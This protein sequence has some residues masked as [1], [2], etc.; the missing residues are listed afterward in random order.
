M[1]PGTKSAASENRD[2]G[3]HPITTQMQRSVPGA[4]TRADLSTPPA[5]RG[6][7]VLIATAIGLLITAAW[8][9]PFVDKTLGENI[10]DTVLGYDA[11]DASIAG[12]L[13]GL[14][15]AFAA[16]LAGTFTACN[17]AAFS[18]IA[19]MMAG[20]SSAT[21]RL[22]VA[23][24]P[25]LWVSVGIVPVA[26]LY[27]GLGA[28]LGDSL[29]QLSSATVGAHALPVRLIQSIVVFGIVGLVFIWMGLAAIGLAR[30]PFGRLTARWSQAPLV[31]MGVLI[32]A[33][34][35]GRPY[36]LFRKLFDY[37]AENGNPFYGALSFLLVALGN[38]ALMA[39]LFAGIALFAGDRLQRWLTAKPGRAAAITGG[40]LLVGG[41]FTFVYWDVRLLSLF[42]YGWFPTMPWV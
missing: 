23:M 29:P 41:V 38:I 11:K 42:G 32:G 28:L 34:L 33:F 5:H 4:P 8:S 12:S 39:V 36:P 26:V 7:L 10:A 35:I 24:R 14:L 3:R 15:F 13:A 27:G 37:A 21:G 17:I 6:R 19:P 30:D 25:I 16:G 2:A 31:V 22:K 18:A 9:A 40:A 20:D 1:E